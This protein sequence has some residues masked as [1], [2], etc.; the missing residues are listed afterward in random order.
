MVPIRTHSALRCRR[1]GPPFRVRRLGSRPR[2][3]NIL[4]LAPGQ[5]WEFAVDDGEHAGDSADG[6]FDGRAGFETRD[7]LITEVAEITLLRSRRNGSEHGRRIQRGG[8]SG[9]DADDFTR[10]CHPA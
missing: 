5:R 2:L 10:S 7:P 9:Q 3:L 8:N 4:T 6:L 1:P